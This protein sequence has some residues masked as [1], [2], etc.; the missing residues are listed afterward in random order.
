MGRLGQ[1]RQRYDETKPD[2]RSKP[3]PDGRY[4]GFIKA[5][6][7]TITKETDRDVFKYEVS[8]LGPS[9]VGRILFV[10][11]YFDNDDSMKMLKT[12]QAVVGMD[13]LEIEDLEDPNKLK[14]FLNVKLEFDVKNK[15]DFCNVYF[16]KRLDGV[17]SAKANGAGS[18]GNG[19]SG[20]GQP[21][22]VG[23]AT[24]PEEEIPF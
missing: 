7:T 2:D 17:V 15:G 6:Y 4:Q 14:P 20:A 8:I 1:Y 16:R 22:A 12:A 21:A 23:A 9:S 11:Y 3:V 18:N 10:N 5:L 24:G 19:S 13:K